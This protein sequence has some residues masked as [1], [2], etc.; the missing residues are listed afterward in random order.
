[1]TEREFLD[2]LSN[3]MRLSGSGCH[4]VAL[5]AIQLRIRTLPTVPPVQSSVY[6]NKTDYT[7]WITLF[8]GLCKNND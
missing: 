8:E 6:F 4:D 7:P 3:A 1:M 5:Q 2:S